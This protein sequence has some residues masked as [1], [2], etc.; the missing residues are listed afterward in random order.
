MPP[1]QTLLLS[2]QAT[3]KS[4]KAGCLSVFLLP[5]AGFLAVGLFVVI[6]ATGAMQG[7]ANQP[8][9]P[10]AT[11]QPGN[12]APLFSPSIRFWGTSIEKWGNQWN[13]EP[14]LI[15]TVMQI[16]SC[17]DPEA[18]SHAGAMGL[19]QVMPFHFKP[20]D[21]AQDP[22]TNAARGLSYL[23]QSLDATN[24]DVRLAL[25]GYNGG[26]SLI[27]QDDSL[28]PDETVNYVYWGSAIYQD[29][30]SGATTSKTLNQWLLKNGWRLCLQASQRLGIKP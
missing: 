27:G 7:P 24:G 4:R 2:S 1:R 15:A 17:G 23:K 5:L 8:Y 12:L 6:A 25:V 28:W 9:G 16:E 19:F 3:R 30:M 13:L 29:A 11:A 18:G 22:E 26:V 10:G 14:N 21:K 20:G